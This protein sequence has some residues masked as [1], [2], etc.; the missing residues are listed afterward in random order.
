MMSSKSS[1][2]CF[3]IIIIT[4]GTDLSSYSAA[5]FDADQYNIALHTG[6][7]YLRQVINQ[8]FVHTKDTQLHV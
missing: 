1:Q 6:L 7:P 2:S 5:P 8:D 3:I 4:T